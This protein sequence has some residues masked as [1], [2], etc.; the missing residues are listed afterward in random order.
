M[1]GT[2]TFLLLAHQ[3]L[4]RHLHI[5]SSRGLSDVLRKVDLRLPGDQLYSLCSVNPWI[6]VLP[7]ATVR[8]FDLVGWTPNVVL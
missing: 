4:R 6:L 5:N 1:G 2:D 3:D 7:L 8:D